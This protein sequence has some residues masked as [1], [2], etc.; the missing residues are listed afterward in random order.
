MASPLSFEG[1]HLRT[2][3]EGGGSKK[4]FRCTSSPATGSLRR[5]SYLSDTG[6]GFLMNPSVQET[7]KSPLVVDWMSTVRFYQSREKRCCMDLQIALKLCW[8]VVVS[9]KRDSAI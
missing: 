5:G 2:L 7:R 3:Q 6:N 1:L 4:S 9:L 8:L